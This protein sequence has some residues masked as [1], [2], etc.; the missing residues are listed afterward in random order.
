MEKSTHAEGPHEEAGH[1]EAS[2]TAAYRANTRILDPALFSDIA[3]PAED[4][5]QRAPAGER[6]MPSEPPPLRPPAAKASATAP[7][8]RPARA[9]LR[10]AHVLFLGAAA[11]ALASFA[12]FRLQRAEPPAPV[13]MAGAPDPTTAIGEPP[14]EASGALAGGAIAPSVVSPTAQLAAPPHMSAPPTKTSAAPSIS[15]VPGSAAA[16]S[17]PAA[18]GTMV[19]PND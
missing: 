11:L 17:R 18:A 3:A 8:P 16:S 13:P 9:P 5:T 7:A 19:F 14:P 6:S 10:R 12:V 4:R 1:A 2:S 15:L